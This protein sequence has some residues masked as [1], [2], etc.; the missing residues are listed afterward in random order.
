MV[1]ILRTT[2]SNKL[3]NK[4]FIFIIE[5][6]LKKVR[7]NYY[8]YSR[9]SEL[10]INK[11]V[12]NNQISDFEIDQTFFS[13]CLQYSSYK[14]NEMTLL[15][16][17]I[18]FKRIDNEEK[19][20]IIILELKNKIINLIKTSDFEKYYNDNLVFFEDK[21]YSKYKKLKKQGKLDLDNNSF[22]SDQIK[23]YEKIIEFDMLYSEYLKNIKKIE[24]IKKRQ[25]NDELFDK[26]GFKVY[27]DWIK[28]NPK[29]E[30]RSH[31]TDIMSEFT[32]LLSVT[33]FKNYYTTN[34]IN[35]QIEYGSLH[36]RDYFEDKKLLLQFSK[37]IQKS[38]NYGNNINWENI[39]LINYEDL[40]EK[41]LK[42]IKEKNKWIREYV[43]TEK[44]KDYFFHL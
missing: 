40:G 37:I 6:I 2:I 24:T 39:G 5:N 7:I 4:D 41:R 12:V 30:S 34:F 9:F 10:L 29:I 3:V 32:N 16:K 11:L 14:T 36:F 33:N 17:P 8:N 27:Q 35:W 13:K 28:Q 20:D 42:Y 44:P 38:I 19:Q 26:Y 1:S 23:N 22:N 25:S 43:I 18:S 21:Q 31:I 15:E